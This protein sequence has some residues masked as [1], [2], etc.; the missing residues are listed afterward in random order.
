[1]IIHVIFYTSYAYSF[2]NIHCDDEGSSFMTFV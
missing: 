2:I 1:M